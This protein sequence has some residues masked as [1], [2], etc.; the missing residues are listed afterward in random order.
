[1][2]T[3]Y[4]TLCTGSGL[5][6][7]F[8]SLNARLIW[9]TIWHISGL[10]LIFLFVI[11]RLEVAF[12]LAFS[13]C[14]FFY[15]SVLTDVWTI[16]CKMSFLVAPVTHNVRHVI[17]GSVWSIWGGCFRI[18]IC[19]IVLT[20]WWCWLWGFI[21]WLIWLLTARG[22]LVCKMTLFFATITGNCA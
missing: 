6:L 9:K 17:V 22:T 18:F 14:I 12:F 10:F 8:L 20:I 7:F 19:K 21:P 2:S 15:L 4:P 13:F 16:R 11:P 5:S 3:L 1:M